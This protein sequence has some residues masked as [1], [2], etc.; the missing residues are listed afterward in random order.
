MDFAFSDEQEEFRATLRRFLAEHAPMTEVRRAFA[1]GDGFDR[2]L[3]KRMAS[4]LG[5]QGIALPGE[6]GGQGFGFLELGIVQEE[7]GRALVPGPFLASAVLAA[8]AIRAAGTPADHAALLPGLAAGDR[9]ATLALVE[10]SGAWSPDSVSSVCRPDG[11]AMLVDGDKPFVLDAVAADL[12]LVAAR[13]PGTRG[14]EG[15]SLVAVESASPGVTIR[16][17]EALDPTRRWGRVELRGARGR[18]LGVPGAAAAPLARALDEAAIALA[19]EMIGGAERCLEMAVAYAKERVQFGRPIGGFQALKHKCAEVL[20]ELE[21]AKSAVYYAGWVA[22]EGRPELAQAASLAKAAAADAYL[23]ASAENVQ[24][25]GGVGFTWE[26][27]PHLFFKRAKTSEILLGDPIRHRD[28]I[29][30][31]L[32]V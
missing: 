20:L 13:A 4:E 26:Y 32:G 22:A 30:S 29:A 14:T 18:T 3:W 27:D 21:G 5:L 7:L 10:A 24:I 23:R 1:S 19:F 8:G 6:H 11:D 2:A 12:L 28:R 9:I 25:H 16:G 17:A 31:S 15:V